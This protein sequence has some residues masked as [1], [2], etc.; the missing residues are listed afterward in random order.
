MTEVIIMGK[1][2]SG[3]LM[4]ISSLPGDYGIGDF[5]KEAY[6]FV[7][8]LVKSKQRNWQI[9]PLGVTGYGD[10]PY[11]CFS[12]FAGNP[13]FI[14]LNE[15]LINHFIDQEDLKKYYI[16]DDDT[17]VNYSLLYKNKM[18]L[19]RIAYTNSKTQLFDELRYYY[20]TNIDWLR[21]FVLFMSIKAKH[22]NVS[23][24]EWAPQY[25]VYNSEAVSSFEE[26]NQDEIYF[27]VFTQY[28]FTRQWNRLKEYANAKG[29]KI[30]GDLPIYV[31]EDSSDLWSNPEYFQLDE[32]LVPKTVAGVPPDGFTDTGQLWGNP[33][34]EWEAMENDGYKWWLRR[35]EHSFKLYDTLR[36]DHFRGF[37][38]YWEVEYGSENAIRGKWVK[39]PGMK[40]FNKIKEELGELDIIVED[41]GYSTPEVTKLVKDSGFPNMKVLQFAFNPYD[42]SQHAPHSF[43][44]NCVVYTSTHD[45]QTIIGW[46]DTL[47][48]DIFQYSVKYLK[49]NYDEGLNWGVIRGA[50]AST[51]N[52]AIATMQDFLGLDDKARMNVPGSLGD[53]WT[54]RLRKGQ[55]TDDLAYRIRELTKMFWR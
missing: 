19:L 26:E 46:F 45:N 36:M 4:H 48:K 5:G 27:W 50:W 49:L 53:N 38:S 8:F 33:I 10:S 16:S 34:Y 42:E 11:Q 2:S 37:E 25:K 39:G 21:E 41:L 6:R 40:L 9:L 12:A 23:W 47:P 35:I 29:I 1:R 51:A 24:Y 43:D 3:I 44:K 22:N 28:Y 7:D 54:W 55:L 14:D 17:K 32:N 31:S 20:I 30:I 52:L 13:Y 15:M 18:K